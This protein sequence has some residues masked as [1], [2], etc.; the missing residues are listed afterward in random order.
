MKKRFFLMGLTLSITLI[1]ASYGKAGTIQYEYDQ[2]NQLTKISQQDA[3]T[4]SYSYDNTGN[5]TEQKVEV[6]TPDFDTDTDGDVDG[7][8][9]AKFLDFWDGSQETLANFALVY[10]SH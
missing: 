4:M 1:Y 7:L 5:R 3:Y 8:D 2:K 10:G 9:L 6:E